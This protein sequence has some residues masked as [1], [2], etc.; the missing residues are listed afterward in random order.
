[1][2][3]CLEPCLPKV[4]CIVHLMWN[5]HTVSS[6]SCYT[7]LEPVVLKAC[8][9]LQFSAIWSLG[10]REK[11]LLAWLLSGVFSCECALAWNLVFPK[12]C[13]I[14]H[15]C[16]VFTLDWSLC[17]LNL[18]FG[19][20]DSTLARWSDVKF[21]HKYKRHSVG[22]WE[23]DSMIAKDLNDSEAPKSQSQISWAGGANFPEPGKTSRCLK[24]TKIRSKRYLVSW[25]SILHIRSNPRYSYWIT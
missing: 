23:L 22:I 3:T 25:L 7:C 16:T 24:Q 10:Q 6:H 17:S 21:P 18:V 4:C 20:F 2:Y 15:S 19:K 9:W 5:P 8:V 12:A 1:M 13:C 11:H 14:V